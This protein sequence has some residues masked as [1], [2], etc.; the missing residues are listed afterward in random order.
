[1][2]PNFGQAPEERKKNPNARRPWPSF[3]PCGASIHFCLLTHGLRR[4][5]RCFRA[6]GA[7]E[8]C[9]GMF[10]PYGARASHT[11]LPTAYAVGYGAFAPTAL[12]E[13]DGDSFTRHCDSKN[14]ERFRNSRESRAAI[15]RPRSRRCDSRGLRT[16]FRDRGAGDAIAVGR[17]RDSATAERSM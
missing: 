10:R 16:R 8:G 11:A 2:A 14:T 13:C 9:D 7:P 17:A 15:P 3:A 6:Y 1:M 5:L 12:E 4:G